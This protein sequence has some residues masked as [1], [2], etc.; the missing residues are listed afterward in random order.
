MTLSEDLLY[1][2]LLLP[3]LTRYC[4]NLFMGLS[5]FWKGSTWDYA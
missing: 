1:Y 2:M 4:L 5:V 3:N